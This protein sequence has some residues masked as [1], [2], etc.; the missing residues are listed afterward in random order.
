VRKAVA[1][2]TALALVLAAA[3]SADAGKPGGK[4]RSGIK[5]VVLSSTC[6]GP[7]IYPPPPEPTYTGEATVTVSRVSNGTPVASS[8]ETDGHFRFRLKRG[9]YD[10]TATPAGATPTPCPPDAVCAAQ[11]AV[12]V[13]P[14]EVGETK[15]VRVK[16]HRFTRV[17]LHI[18]NACVA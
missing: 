4:K 5:G 13:M 17:E 7:C 6:S 15:R 10:V 14:C 11:S 12:V 1:A 16:R 8:K 3:V 2:L 9:L 18:Q